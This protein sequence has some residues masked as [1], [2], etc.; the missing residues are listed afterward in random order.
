MVLPLP[1][2]FPF[3]VNVSIRQTLSPQALTKY[4]NT[5]TYPE[6][7]EQNTYRNEENR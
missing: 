2:T 6:A 4:F 1:P 3:S 5:P 7:V